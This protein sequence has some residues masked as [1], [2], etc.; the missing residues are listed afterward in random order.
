MLLIAAA[1]VF[2]LVLA[3]SASLFRGK[4]REVE[5]ETYPTGS[6]AELNFTIDTGDYIN[7]VS[8]IAPNYPTITLTLVGERANGTPTTFWYAER[9][10]IGIPGADATWK[11]ILND[12]SSDLVCELYTDDIVGENEFY[13]KYVYF[14]TVIQKQNPATGE[15]EYSEYLNPEFVDLIVDNTTSVHSYEISDVQ[16]FYIDG[17]GVEAPY[18]EIV[19][20]STSIIFK[21]FSYSITTPNNYFEYCFAD[22]Q[23]LVDGVPA[24]EIW[25]PATTKLDFGVYYAEVR[26][27][28]TYSGEITF[29]SMDRAASATY[30]FDARKEIKLDVRVPYIRVD[31]V[32]DIP[33]AP[34]PYETDTYSAYNVIFFVTPSVAIGDVDPSR[35]GSGVR[36]E[37]YKGEQLNGERVWET[38]TTQN[39]G[40]YIFLAERTYT[41]LAF[42]GV[43]DAGMDSYREG[44][45]GSNTFRVYIDK[46]RPVIQLTATDYTNANILTLGS[47]PRDGY[48]VGYASDSVRFILRNVASYG[49]GGSHSQIRFMYAIDDGGTPV[50]RE[51]STE[52][53]YEKNFNDQFINRKFIFK[54][55]SEAGLSD[56]VE[57]TVSVLKRNFVF[58]WAEEIL[59]ETNAAGWA[60]EQ[61][62]VYFRL[63]IILDAP[64][65]Y[66][67]YSQITGNSASARPVSATRISVSYNPV[68]QMTYGEFK[69]YIDRSLNNQTID[70]YAYNKAGDS[71]AHLVTPIPIKLDLVNPA[72]DIV[73]RISNSSLVLTEDDWANGSVVVNIIPSSSNISGIKCYPLLSG[74]RLG[75]LQL[76]GGRFS[77]TFDTASNDPNDPFKAGIK[78]CYYAL[79]SGADRV[80]NITV[81]V[82]I[83]TNRI[84]WQSGGMKAYVSEYAEG[85]SSQERLL[86]FESTSGDSRRINET[87]SSDVKLDFLS[88]HAGHF[89]LYYQQYTTANPDP[90]AYLRLDSET[91][92]VPV[93]LIAGAAQGTV[94]Y[95][96]YLSSKARDGS[97][98]AS[99]TND[100]RVEIKYNIKD[101]TIS[102][103]AEGTTD[104]TR[105]DII[106]RINTAQAEGSV[107]ISYYQI[108]LVT[109]SGALLLWQ[110]VQV[111]DDPEN[112][113]VKIYRFAGVQQYN[114]LNNR[115][116]GMAFKGKIQFRAFNTAGRASQVVEDVPIMIDKTRPDPI[117]A[118]RQTAGAEMI[119][120]E[121][122]NDVYTVYGTAAGVTLMS[123][124]N[125][126]VF[127]NLAP[128]SYY[129]CNPSSNPPTSP[130]D[131]R[132]V[133]LAAALTV[134]T[135]GTYYMYAKNT[136]GGGD[137]Y[138][139]VFTFHISIED[140][141]PTAT[142]SASGAAI[143]VSGIYEFNWKSAA[144]VSISA[145][146][147]TKVYYEY[148][149][150]ATGSWLRYNPI[151]EA[152]GGVK[153]LFFLGAADP[154][155]P[156][157][158]IGNM[159]ET[160]RFRV[161]NLAGSIA[162]FA[163]D[164]VVR[165]RLD[166]RIP[167]FDLTTTVGGQV[168][169]REAWQSSQV[170]IRLFPVETVGGVSRPID[171]VLANPGGVDYTYRLSENSNY[172][173]L[174]GDGTF[175]STDDLIDFLDADHLFVNGNGTVTIHILARAKE[176][177][178]QYRV[179]VTLHIDK[180]LPVFELAGEITVPGTAN[181]ARITS[182]TWTQASV[183]RISKD[184]IANSY[185]NVS[186][187]Y[188][189]D[190]DVH[191]IS[192]WNGS[193][194]LEYNV[195]CTLYVTAVS[196][197][198]LRVDRSFA[199]K[200]D[201][202]PPL[203]NSGIIV[204]AMKLDE[205]GN[206]VIDRE[207]PNTYYIDQIIT[208]IEPNLSTA[209]Y[210]NFPLTNGK[211]IATNTVDNSNTGGL[212]EGKGG[213]VHIVVTDLAGNKTE[214][215][216]YMT[217]FELDINNITLSD[218]HK[219]LLEK[220]EEQFEQ[221]KS[222]LTPDRLAY[223]ES[224]ISRLEDRL[225]TL[226][227]QVNEYRHYLV[228]IN[229][230]S[231]FTLIDDYSKMQ[232][233][234]N[235]FTTRDETIL[236]PEWQQIMIKEDGYGVYYN[237][238]VNEFNKLDILASAV[239]S[240]E[241]SI[242]SLPAINVV[243][244]ADYADILRVFNA[245][246]SL[247]ITQKEY[248]LTNL[249]KKL[250]GL[251]RACEILLL[252]DEATGIKIEGD[253]LAPGVAIQVFNYEKTTAFVNNAQ[254]TL[255][256][257]IAEGS[258]RALI[259]V[260][261]LGLTDFGSQYTTGRIKIT[262]PIPKEFQNYITFGVYR[263][264]SDGT[265]IPVQDVIINADGESVYF[266]ANSLDTYILAVGAEPT[267]RPP[268]EKIYGRI[269]DV[270]ID[271][272]LL[273]YIS[274]ASIGMFVLLL[275]IVVIVV[276]RHRGFL[277][278]Y[279]KSYKNS[280]KSRGISKIPK[281][282]APARSNPAAIGEKFDYKKNIFQNK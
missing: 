101:F 245:Y 185:S 17:A 16:T 61:I 110:T 154:N 33:G 27:D 88:N 95:S 251:K 35:R 195:I 206:E 4:G 93:S 103:S 227:R 192:P 220:Y 21:I 76:S 280:L 145:S 257:T 253:N 215:I 108:R 127:N 134:R 53:I 9:D 87:V 176:S 222:G 216:F 102:V 246:D 67:F 139:N 207:H 57:F 167:E 30:D 152:P 31:P 169:S 149:I 10:R 132:F 242:A 114:T 240:I 238:L 123:T 122:S 282:N 135:T 69:T 26:I 199:V 54:A 266:F 96:F 159:D 189:T 109:Y 46:V 129:Y 7:G 138:S 14:K 150:G 229:G 223:F 120:V 28:E 78:Y 274:Y 267:V 25:L 258:P 13:S 224:N 237:K 182:G 8:A 273:S 209:F 97:G 230:K 38:I 20:R 268:S 133:P 200:I 99:E 121:G 186:Y 42:K 275:V 231:L 172:L 197:S 263:L 77:Q 183:V 68:D 143:G 1:V 160:V 82:K 55:E 254:L 205:N 270:L 187:T 24:S 81:T 89:V 140:F 60:R 208:Y 278:K 5:A 162:T 116:L 71:S 83:D 90:G 6:L 104:W 43:S 256:E 175:F 118:V 163:N 106:F 75:E 105:D 144:I 125:L 92:T 45:G 217:I 213:Y 32:K 201:N 239:R 260:K 188:Y 130:G 142:L 48:K 137:S 228:E 18:D 164:A 248:L 161:V 15:Y 170:F 63:P 276:L 34:V 115:E 37:V 91:F 49:E 262:L 19:W 117:H 202:D 196:Q 128:I 146:S 226:Q 249:Y 119:A 232:T 156:N 47:A 74:E 157:A 233:Y 252:Q 225:A 236:Y 255:L 59:V 65:E 66:V 269:G 235:Y 113:D 212:A 85:G 70:F 62:P 198:G 58:E 148:K 180:V 40:V 111:E 264:L 124:S 126:A 219:N 151:A 181:T 171:P 155:Y 39:E 204:N 281:G 250:V 179:D 218:E 64:D 86:T 214:L 44:G 23:T 247:L 3:L 56:T 261:K 147:R 190:L 165:I 100:L 166:V 279:N 168:I 259:Y 153:E 94:Y 221:G 98:A 271:A 177:D 41:E 241:A 50:F 210:N 11:Q 107:D 84:A 72:A 136:I 52:S 244:R 194:P 243:K 112:S 272:T 73:K 203:I 234:I 131:P 173:P 80:T 193:N 277:K 36:Y 184:K 141:A 178:R 29:R 265:L 22:D 191:N 79:V 174:P 2:I 51:A 12:D 158:V 211:I